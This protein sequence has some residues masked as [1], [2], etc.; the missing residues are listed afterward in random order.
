MNKSE[1]TCKKA[2][3]PRMTVELFIMVLNEVIKRLKS[4]KRS[5]L[6]E[7]LEQIVLN[8]YTVIKFQREEE[9]EEGEV[10]G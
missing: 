2:A 7:P 3:M 8:K 1:L 9:R 4:G 10:K 5:M 6:N